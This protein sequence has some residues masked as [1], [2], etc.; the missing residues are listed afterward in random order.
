[1]KA[2]QSGQPFKAHA[3]ATTDWFYTTAN[4]YPSLNSTAFA[5]AEQFAA[6]LEPGGCVSPRVL[7]VSISYACNQVFGAAVN[8]QLRVRERGGGVQGRKKHK[9]LGK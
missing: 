2:F 9:E 6:S 3:Q 4:L 7:K 1:M 8:Y 5:A